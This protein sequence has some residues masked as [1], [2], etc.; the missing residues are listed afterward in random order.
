MHGICEHEEGAEGVHGHV[1]CGI[2]EHVVGQEEVGLAAC[3][4]GLVVIGADEV[5][6]ARGD[7]EQGVLDGHVLEGEVGD[8]GGGIDDV[9]LAGLHLRHVG[10]ADGHGRSVVGVAVER[11]DVASCQRACGNLLGREREGQAEGVPLVALQRAAVD[12]DGADQ[13][14][15]GFDDAGVVGSVLEQVAH[16]LYVD[17]GVVTARGPLGL[18][19]VGVEDVAQGLH[20]SFV[21]EVVIA[22]INPSQCLGVGVAIDVADT[23]VKIESIRADVC[24]AGTDGEGLQVCALAE[25]I[26]A[27]GRHAGGDDHVLQVLA[28]EESFVAD[29]FQGIGEGDIHHAG[30][31]VEASGGYL[32]GSI[33][34]FDV[35]GSR[36]FVVVGNVAKIAQASSQI[37]QPFGVFER[38]IPDE[39]QI[40]TTSHSDGFQVF[41]SMKCPIADALHALG[42]GNGL[43]AL[44][45]LK[46]V[47][48]NLR[49]STFDGEV[50]IS[51]HGTF[52]FIRNCVDS[53]QTVGLCIQ[54]GSVVKSR[55]TDAR[56]G[57]GKT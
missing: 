15:G 40:G 4:E 29:G 24:H 20:I 54:P 51:R 57:G 50:C 11:A 2:V 49:C 37:I 17:I 22:V 13:A 47:S 25:G 3:I 36:A 23:L 21:I 35:G 56:H 48:H 28:I 30:L 42:D 32:G 6:V 44:L 1:G 19:G 38:I 14:V 52:I 33:G 7:G 12:G 18:E 26:L 8:V 34:N 9:G 41:A 39:L 55:V 27:D 5:G 43:Q 16:E 10:K 31:C 45:T 53:Y 46:A